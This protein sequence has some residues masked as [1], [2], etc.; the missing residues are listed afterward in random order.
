ME[1]KKYTL[2]REREIYACRYCDYHSCYMDR[3]TSTLDCSCHHPSID[4]RNIE[5][6]GSNEFPVWCPL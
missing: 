4:Y 6:G 1:V 2:V 5:K 3:D